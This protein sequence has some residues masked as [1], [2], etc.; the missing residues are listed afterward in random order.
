MNT[1]TLKTAINSVKTDNNNRQA[2]KALANSLNVSFDENITISG[3]RE[4]RYNWGEIAEC[5]IRLAYGEKGAKQGPRQADLTYKGVDYEIK[6]INRDGKPS[7]TKSAT[8]QTPTL[9]FA[10]LSSFPRGIYKIPYGA[11]VWNTSNHMVAVPTLEK[12]KL[13]KA[14]WIKPKGAT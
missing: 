3:K 13:L 10:N 4:G 9:I 14:F 11:I 2:L 1:T 5:I 6:A 8:A 12:A 7:K